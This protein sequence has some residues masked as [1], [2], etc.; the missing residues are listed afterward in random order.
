MKRQQQKAEPLLGRNGLLSDDQDTPA[1]ALYVSRCKSHR[2]GLVAVGGDDWHAEFLGQ[3]KRSPEQER[4]RA[5]ELATRLVR[6]WA[7]R[8]GLTIDAPSHVFESRP[9]SGSIRWTAS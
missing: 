9:K 5:R 7:R 1:H 6:R 4:A 3:S 2:K 8:K